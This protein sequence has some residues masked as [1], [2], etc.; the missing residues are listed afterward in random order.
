MRTPGPP[1][2]APGWC[3]QSR[4]SC[5]CGGRSRERLGSVRQRPEN[6][7]ELSDAD[8][9]FT[10]HLPHSHRNSLDRARPAALLSARHEHDR[11]APQQHVVAHG[12]REALLA[13]RQELAGDRVELLLADAARLVVAAVGAYACGGQGRPKVSSARRATS[14]QTNAPRPSDAPRVEPRCVR[15]EG[16]GP[17]LDGLQDGCVTAGGLDDVGD[18]RPRRLRHVEW[19]RH[20]LQVLV[21]LAAARVL[22]AVVEGHAALG[23]GAQHLH[24]RAQVPR[25]EGVRLGLELPR[26]DQDVLRGRSGRVD[27]NFAVGD[28]NVAVKARAR[29]GSPPPA[30]GHSSTQRAN[31]VR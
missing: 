10:I 3:R 17:E 20:D 1:P 4:E 19:Q 14:T 5:C 22:A 16:Q 26:D 31:F 9:S 25:V 24:R 23:H 11:L 29:R 18:R 8:C 15:P 6:P 12:L 21:G 28:A 13:R 30:L 27:G 7:R 2:S